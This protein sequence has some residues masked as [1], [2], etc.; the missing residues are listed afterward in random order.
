LFAEVQRQKQFSQSLV[1]NTPVAIVALTAED[2]ITSWNPAAERLFGYTEVE[3]L[4]RQVEDL[5]TSSETRD[6]ALRFLAHALAG[7]RIHAVT[8]RRRKDGSTVDVELLGVPVSTGDG[9][10]GLVAIYHDIT[11]LKE[12]ARAIEESQRRLADIIGFLPDATLV[13]DAEGKVIAWNRAMEEMTGVPA[14]DM[15]GKG[16]YQYSLPFY[17]T[18]RPILI[19]L[20][21]LPDEE[22]EAR[23][24]H[25]ERH[26]ARL[27][28]EALVPALRGRQAYLY[29]TASALRDSRGEIVGAIE[30][31]RDI[32][33]RK[34]A[35]E[36]LQQAKAAA[37]AATQAKSAFLATMSHEIRTPM[38]AVIGMTSLLLDTPLNP[39]QHEFAETIRS[40]GD[41][42]LAVIND[43][44]DFSKIEAGRIDLERQPFDVRECVESAVGLVAGQAA[45]RGLELSCWIDPHVPVG[46][47]GDETRLRQIVL[48]LLS[49][50][51]KFTEK[52][53]VAV[54]VTASA[55]RRTEGSSVSLHIA[56]RDTGLG[57]PP[58]RMD[59]LFQS[60]SQVDSSTTRKYGGTGLGLAISERLV[61]LMGGRMWAESA[62]IPGQGSTFHFTI[63]AEPVSIPS[64]SE[65]QGEVPDLQGRRVL[66][67]DDS[68]TSRRILT[69]QTKS[70]GMVPRA[71]GSPS[72]ALEWVRAG[73]VFDVAIL[74]RQM[75]EMDGVTLAVELHRLREAR[76]LPLVMVS[77]LG[78]GEGEESKELAAF[79]V[80]PVRPSQLY[81]ALVGILAGRD[82]QVARPAA[83]AP[84]F[85]AEMGRR[86]P[87]RILLAE[88]N[89]VNQ[90]LALRLLERLG[91]RADVAANG[92]EA[93]RAVER[94]PYDVVFMDVQM[95]E[96]DGLEATRQ[97]V[98]RWGKAERPRIIAM[99]ANALAEDRE[100]CLAAGMDDY[101]AK[102]IRVAELVAALGRT[103][104]LA[105]PR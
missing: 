83:A 68:A 64:R 28:G 100:A 13:I 97:I 21:L 104:P 37:E 20:V 32:S 88:D 31:I 12:A 44:L 59:R 62:G 29:A 69:L 75:P 45:A 51:L 91:Y 49:N 57:I 36:E 81:N 38:N 102:P 92:V 61:D 55:S 89:V 101:L 85:D 9:E 72:E 74:D 105:P 2:R 19:D 52:G 80:K 76:L 86:Q 24:A 18:R 4:G 77:S 87:L 35:E 1:E 67:V 79:L 70:W 78:R 65:L 7:G 95:P 40:S 93:I 99:T 56:V 98:G 43:I 90:K 71:T 25:I 23:Y 53:E 73:E 3:A 54:G 42:L 22:L 6:E 27:I 15:L 66:V 50:A 14:Q 11:E 8:Q 46:I 16:D 103:S 47:L 63:E 60:F 30:T 48:N 96:M 26:G 33:D 84:R 5:I 17:G 34:Q 58:D 82:A 10:T 94:Q 39:E 41:A